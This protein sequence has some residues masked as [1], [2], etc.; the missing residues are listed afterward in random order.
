MED[1]KNIFTDKLTK[2]KCDAFI[3]RWPLVNLEEGRVV[4]RKCISNKYNKNKFPILMGQPIANDITHT[5]THTKER[6]KYNFHIGTLKS[7]TTNPPPVSHQI[8][9]PSV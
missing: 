8:L 7:L 5:H 9:L 4:A 6:Y 3:L 1:T 2:K